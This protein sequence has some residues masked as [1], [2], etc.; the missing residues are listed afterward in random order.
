V[1]LTP[2][3][4]T[5][6]EPPPPPELLHADTPSAATASPAISPRLPVLLVIV[7]L[8]LMTAASLHR[9]GADHAGN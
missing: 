7:L 3:S 2:K 8:R 4:L 9:P 6:A 1:A 5:L